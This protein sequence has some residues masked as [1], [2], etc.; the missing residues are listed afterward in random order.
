MKLLELIVKNVSREELPE[1]YSG[2]G[3][4]GVHDDKYVCGSQ[5]GMNWNINHFRRIAQLAEIGDFVTREDLMRAY[6]LVEQGYTLWFGGECPVDDGVVVDVVFRDGSN[7]SEE[8]VEYCTWK[9]PGDDDDIIAYRVIG[10]QGRKGEG[11]GDSLSSSNEL[12]RLISS[13][14]PN[15]TLSDALEIADTLID[16]GYHK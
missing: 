3:V 15:I 6:D 1:E 10:T 4:F 8:N 12:I 9:Q 16:A 14:A 11:G 2:F 5:N 7:D 13:V